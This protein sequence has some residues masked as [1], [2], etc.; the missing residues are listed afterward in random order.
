MPVPTAA[1]ANDTTAAPVEK[2]VLTAEPKIPEPVPTAATVNDTTVAPVEKQVL[3]AEPKIPEPVPTAA[4]VNDTTVAP[5]EKQALTAEPKIP[6]VGSSTPKTIA[7]V[8]TKV[9]PAIPEP[10]VVSYGLN[11]SGIDLEG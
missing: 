2:Q 8:A 4:A 5:V 10:T 11:D 7:N 9:V 1:A 6:V 3:T